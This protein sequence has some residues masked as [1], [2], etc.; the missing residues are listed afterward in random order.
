MTKKN[1][2]ASNG[3]S[4]NVSSND[5]VVKI[6]IALCA[7]AFIVFLFMMITDKYGVAETFLEVREAIRSGSIISA[8]AAVFGLVTALTGKFALKNK[9]VTA[10]GAIVLVVG[11][12]FA[13]G[14]LALYLYYIKAA[15][16]IYFAIPSIALLYLIYCIYQKPFFLISV[17][18]FSCGFGF[19]VLSKLLGY[20]SVP[21][22]YYV[23]IAI[24]AALIICLTVIALLARK[25]KG[26]LF[27]KIKLIDSPSSYPLMYASSAFFA[28][29]LVASV[30]MGASVSY[31][32]LFLSMAYFFV[33]A[34]YYTIKL[35]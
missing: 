27:G 24:M 4:K 16:I 34:I 31:I 1:R 11:V 10:A 8:C 20:G 6:I 21:T 22:L 13:I 5:S 18:S 33:M 35:M 12:I 2:T 15:Q 28:V 19:Y 17:L 23:V 32:S 9:T 29:I 26:M 30:I 7:A 14:L 3:V 25:D